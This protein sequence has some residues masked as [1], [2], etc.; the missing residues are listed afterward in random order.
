MRV[1]ILSQY[2][3]PEVDH[4]CLPL[5]KAVM[6]AG[7]EVEILTGY[8]NRPSGKLYPGYKMKLKYSE[9]IEGVKVNRVPS[10]LNHSHSGLKRMFSYLTFA[11]SAS[12]IG[13]FLIKRPHVIYAYHAPATIAIPAIFFRF[14]LRSKVFYDINDYWPD[15]ISALG[16]LKSK[17]LLKVLAA[18]CKKTYQYFDTI[19]VVSKGYKKKLLELA[20]PNDKISLIYNWSLP[21]DN[22]KSSFFEKYRDV[23]KDNFVILYAGNIGQAQSLDIIIDVAK[24][25]RENNQTGIKFFIV[26]SGVEEM[27]LQKQVIENDL[28]EVIYFTG[29]IPSDNVGEFLESADILLLHLKKQPLFDIT[30]PSKL[31]SYFIFSKPVLCGVGGES[32]EIV[33][34]SKAGLCFEPENTDDLYNKIISLK[35]YSKSE[36]N[37]MGKAGREIYDNSFSFEKGTALMIKEFS[38]LYSQS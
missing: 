10:Y 28:S 31:V 3:W 26:G 11:F 12:F 9:Y 24:K 25:L 23:F 14:V 7:H 1:L 37:D 33:S 32:A 27:L 6:A 20:V 29:F 2:C 35:S 34:D 4:K 38:D 17:F 18:Y 5:A 15:T 21:I 19:N 36:L 8:P 13:V 30:I 16:M 22:I